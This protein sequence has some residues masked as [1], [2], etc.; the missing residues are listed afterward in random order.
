MSRNNFF[1]MRSDIKSGLTF[2]C[3]VAFY[4][5]EFVGGLT[6]HSTLAGEY[7]TVVAM[8]QMSVNTGEGVRGKNKG[9]V[10]Q[11]LS[12]IVKEAEIKRG[13]FRAGNRGT[14]LR[15]RN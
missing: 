13:P 12:R 2:D 8:P 9:E 4:P 6:R 7:A 1:D 14:H 10:W 5:P 11:F 3:R 15:G